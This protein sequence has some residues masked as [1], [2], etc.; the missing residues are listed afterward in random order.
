LSHY[1]RSVQAFGVSARIVLRTYAA[2]ARRQVLLTNGASLIAQML[3]IALDRHIPVWTDAA[4]GDLIVEDGRVVGV[5]A[6][7]AGQPVSIRARQGVLLS[8]GG[9]AHNRAM[10]G[11]FGGDQPNG[12]KWSMAN[13]GDT[14]EALQTAM[15]LGAK[16]DL[17]DEAWWL[18]SPR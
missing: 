11:Q 1:N 9:F 17:M 6:V 8:A 2:K 4:L 16:T 12:A 5:R 15:R 3:N 18:P 7:R 10:R 13:P 14:G